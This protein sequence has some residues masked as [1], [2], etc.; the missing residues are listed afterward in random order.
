MTKT[1]QVNIWPKIVPGR[2]N[3]F[4]YKKKIHPFF[5]THLAILRLVKIYQHWFHYN[6]VRLCSRVG[7]CEGQAAGIFAA[8]AHS[9]TTPGCREWWCLD[10]VFIFLICVTSRASPGSCWGLIDTLMSVQVCLRKDHS[11]SPGPI[12]KILF[13]PGEALILEFCNA[14]LLCYFSFRD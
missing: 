5:S 9:W 1:M 13:L 7:S 10:V 2:E 4:S 6:G 8:F 14:L 3:H 12:S 11:N